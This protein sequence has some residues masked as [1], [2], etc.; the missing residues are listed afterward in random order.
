[1][2]IYL[3]AISR[4]KPQHIEQFKALLLA[5]VVESRKEEACIQ[6]DL[7]QSSDDPALFIFHEEWAS[8]EALELH[9]QTAHINKFIKDSVD[10]IDGTVVIHET[11]KLA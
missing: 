6:Y 8:K 5:L 11:D 10:I 3:T 4:A 2:S 7:H 1:M 9:N